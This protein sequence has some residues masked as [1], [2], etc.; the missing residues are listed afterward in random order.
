MLFFTAYNDEYCNAW[1]KIEKTEDNKVKDVRNLCRLK[2]IVDN[3][4]KDIRN[5]FSLHKK[6]RR[7]RR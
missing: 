2:K 6:K 5:L 7:N 3:T 4:I 1:K